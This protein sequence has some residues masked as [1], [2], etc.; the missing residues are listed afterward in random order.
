MF[1]LKVHVN[2]FLFLQI[3]VNYQSLECLMEQGIAANDIQKLSDA[4][5]YTIESVSRY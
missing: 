1:S 4:G 3:T 2:L 5:Y